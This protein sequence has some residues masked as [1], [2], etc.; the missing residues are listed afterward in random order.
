MLDSTI[1]YSLPFSDRYHAT[2]R[3]LRDLPGVIARTRAHIEQ[4]QAYLAQCERQYAEFEAL[5]DHMVEHDADQLA[6]IEEHHRSIRAILRT[7][8][9]K[10]PEYGAE[11]APGRPETGGEPR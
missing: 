7:A 5:M 3:A 10:M 2:R 6:A 8:G 11:T 4:Q 1:G 9:W